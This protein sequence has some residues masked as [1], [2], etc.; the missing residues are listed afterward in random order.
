MNLGLGSAFPG[1]VFVVQDGS[2]T[3]GNQNFK[4]V[5]WPAIASAASPPLLVDSTYRGGRALT[6]DH[7]RPA[8]A[9]TRRTGTARGSIR[10]C[11]PTCARRGWEACWPSTWTAPGTLRTWPTS[12]PT[13]GPPRGA[14]TCG[15]RRSSI[16]RA[17]TTSRSR[18]RTRGTRSASSRASPMTSGC[19]GSILQGLCMGAPGPK[20]PTPPSRIGF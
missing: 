4:L 2:N 10:S 8:R 1:G 9:R 20:R 19:A 11:S 7:P 13:P 17:R 15:G 3:G 12:R 16:P 14:S 18:R 5:P 6:Y